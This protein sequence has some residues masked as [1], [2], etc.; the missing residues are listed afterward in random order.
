MNLWKQNF[1][2]FSLAFEKNYNT[3]YALLRMIA[4]WKTQWYKRKKIGVII[5][6]LSK[7]FDTLNHNLLAVYLKHTV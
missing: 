2:N 6:D 3:Q 4:S 1:P 7:A 5:M